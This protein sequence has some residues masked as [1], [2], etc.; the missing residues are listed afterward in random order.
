MMRNSKRIK[1]IHLNMDNNENLFLYGIVST[2]PDYKLSLALNKKIGI[3]L[4]SKLPLNLSD[5]SG[6]ELIFSR[7]AYTNHSYN[8]VYSLISNR[9]GKQFLLKKLKNIDFLFQVHYS[10][11]ENK[12]SE[13]TAQLRETEAINAVFVVDA[14]TLNDKNLQYII[15]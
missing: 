9:A 10:G 3:S 2:E 5:E 15:T 12:E 14:L 1:R 7:F 13:L 11:S 4:K 6:N 8:I